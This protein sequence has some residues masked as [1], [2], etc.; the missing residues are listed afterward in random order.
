LEAGQPIIRFWRNERLPLS[1]DY[2]NDKSLL[3]KLR[4]A[5]EALGRRT[6]MVLMESGLQPRP[7]CLIEFTSGPAA[8]QEGCQGHVVKHWQ[9]D[10]LYWSQLEAP[11][12]SRLLIALPDGSFRSR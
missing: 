5:A 11:F 12:Q 2:L 1:P 8:R 9:P 4:E 3:D 6:P 7:A 10:S